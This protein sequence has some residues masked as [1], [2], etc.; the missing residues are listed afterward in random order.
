MFLAMQATDALK[1][2]SSGCVRGG[3]YFVRDPKLFISLNLDLRRS[4]KRNTNLV[5]SP[6]LTILFSFTDIFY[7]SARHL[8]LLHSFFLHHSHQI[9]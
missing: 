2:R 5:T 4:I 8:V 9:L 1:L 6:R 7:F 3:F